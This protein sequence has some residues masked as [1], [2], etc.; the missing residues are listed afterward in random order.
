MPHHHHHHSSSRFTTRTSAIISLLS[1]VALLVRAPARAAHSFV[2]NNIVPTHQPSFSHAI[3]AFT[4][5]SLAMSSSS[6]SSFL[7][8][9]SSQ[10]MKKRVLVPIANGSEEIETTCITDT[11]VRFGAH[12]VIASVHGSSE[13]DAKNDKKNDNDNN[14]NNNDDLICKMSRGIKVMADTTMSQAA[15]EEWDLIVLPGG[16]P[17]E[18]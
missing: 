6:S 17:G 2:F 10:T 12:V 13:Q 11:L 4:S 16:M 7:A 5:S 18:C 15:K 1:A 9:A 14:N 3:G 8:S